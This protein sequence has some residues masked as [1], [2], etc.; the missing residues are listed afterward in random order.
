MNM[1]CSDFL[2]TALNVL[3]MA[4][5]L[6]LLG[7]NYLYL[8]V[9]DEYIHTLFPRLAAVIS[10]PISMPDYFTAEKNNI[11][12]HVSVIYP[13]EK[14]MQHNVDHT[15]KDYSFEVCGLFSQK[16]HHKIYYALHIQAPELL[17]IRQQYHLPDQLNFRGYN[18]G[19]HMTLAVLYNDA[20]K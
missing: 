9:S 13:E 3:P 7:G 8:D 10:A 11:G 14:V 19:F 12:A 17:N 6:K 2:T 5:R 18:I 15:D 4:G 16:I 1:I 20:A